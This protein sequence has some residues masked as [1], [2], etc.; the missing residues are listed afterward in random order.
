[1]GYNDDYAAGKRAAAAQAASQEWAIQDAATGKWRT[2]DNGWTDD[3][4]KAGIWKEYHEAARAL[5]DNYFPIRK[6]ARIVPAPPREMTD[7]ECW[8]WF[9]TKW[10]HALSADGPGKTGCWG[11][12]HIDSLGVDIATGE[13]PCDAIRAAR[14]KLESK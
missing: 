11:V 6:A 3:S 10:Q 9:K 8:A 4:S 12:Y 5:G 13:T 2:W 1:M 7:E 14:K